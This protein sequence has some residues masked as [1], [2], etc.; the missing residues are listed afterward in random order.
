LLLLVSALQ[1]GFLIGPATRRPPQRAHR[2]ST[3]ALRSL[4]RAPLTMAD[5]CVRIGDTLE[6][7][8]D[9]GPDE[10][11]EDLVWAAAT[12]SDVDGSSGEFS[13]LVNEWA[14]LP[15]DEPG[16]E[17]E[18]EE[19]P[20][21][22]NGENVEWRRTLPSAL[23][24][25]AHSMPRGVVTLLGE[26]TA[27][28]LSGGGRRLPEHRARDL[29]KYEAAWWRQDSTTVQ[30]IVRLPAKDEFNFK[31][32]CKL[33]FDAEQL[34]LSLFGGKVLDGVW[35]HPI[36][37]SGS[38]YVVDDSVA[39]F[40]GVGGRAGARF[41]EFRLRKASRGREWPALL[42]PEGEM[43]GETAVVQS[44][45]GV[46]ITAPSVPVE[47]NAENMEASITGPKPKTM[48]TTPAAPGA[49]P[50]APAAPAAAKEDVKISIRV[51]KKASF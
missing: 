45:D 22:A 30:L 31:R 47:V 8:V 13:V 10:G 26:L 2:F 46:T 35:A 49:A 41:L 44:G 27:A 12:V 1:A 15:V 3:D 24:Q 39:G 6:V 14:S 23:A 16:Y 18:Y 17:E 48:T 50:S 43:R 40:E 9:Q 32:D 7:E 33:E 42:L 29:R 28:R 37:V 5:V 19:G 20:Y 36:D 25:S 4:R 38:E 34:S 21:L 51:K 11:P